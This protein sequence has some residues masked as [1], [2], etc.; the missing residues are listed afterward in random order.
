MKRIIKLAIVLV[1]V[2]LFLGGC[3]IGWDRHGRGG[4]RGHD[5][6]GKHDSGG[7]HYEQ[8]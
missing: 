4:G 2:A 5:K 7:G 8:H 3:W 6:G 1:L